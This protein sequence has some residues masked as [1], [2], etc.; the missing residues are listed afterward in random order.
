MRCIARLLMFAIL[1]LIVAAGP[2]DDFDRP[3]A[4]RHVDLGP[5]ETSP[6][7]HSEVR[8]HDY[9]HFTVKE[10]DEREVGAAQLSILPRTGAAPPCRRANLPGEQVIAE[11]VWQGY[12]AGAWGDMAVFDA[13]DGVNGAMAFAIFRPGD[14]K[15]RYTA[16][17]FGSPAFTPAPGGGVLR[18][19][20]MVAGDCSVVIDGAACAQR[21]AAA[22][23]V[24]PIKVEACRA[25]Y[26][27]EKRAM[28]RARCADRK[29]SDAACIAAELSGMASWDASPS[30]LAI[31]FAVTFRDGTADARPQGAPTACRPAD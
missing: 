27:A 28:A 31:P 13:A 17:A 30:V 15:P 16:A 2:R 24:A 22:A 11:D 6:A 26:D 5:S 12:F 1:P 25:G 4:V 19:S 21:I 29:R 14:S 7:Q 20:R 18:F 3:L 23:G 8:C 10:I 9:P